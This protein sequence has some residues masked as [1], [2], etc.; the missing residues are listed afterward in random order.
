MTLWLAIVATPRLDTA[1][2][3]ELLRTLASLRAL[4]LPVAIVEV[5]AGV[6]ALSGAA[7]LTPDG[8]R[9]HAVL[10]EDGIVVR[11]PEALVELLPR[12]RAIL[13][14]APTSRTGVPA[15]LRVPLGSAMTQ[16]IDTALSTAGQ[17]I[18]VGSVP[19]PAS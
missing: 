2:G 7:E 10:V 9:F 18:V 4:D 15:V 12:A 16:E 17:A 6:G 19:H 3:T 14:L 8:E 1:E 13:R 11:P 5:G